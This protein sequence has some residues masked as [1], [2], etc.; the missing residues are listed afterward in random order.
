MFNIFDILN[1]STR[2]Q[3][4]ILN[5]R[6]EELSSITSLVDPNKFPIFSLMEALDE[7][8]LVSLFDYKS[9]VKEKIKEEMGFILDVK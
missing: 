3:D 6:Y 7:N 9:E 8:D 4:L 1:K 2:N 5:R